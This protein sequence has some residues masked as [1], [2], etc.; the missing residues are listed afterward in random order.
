MA[1][2][3]RRLFLRFFDNDLF[4]RCIAGPLYIAIT[5]NAF[6]FGHVLAVDTQLSGQ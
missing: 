2:L 3:Q 5:L 1:S 6:T 4:K